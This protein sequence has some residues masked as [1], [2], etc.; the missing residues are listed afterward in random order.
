M[1]Y[2]LLT[3]INWAQR[4]IWLSEF[5]LICNFSLRHSTY[6]YIFQLHVTFALF[7]L[8]RNL[9]PTRTFRFHEILMLANGCIKEK[10]LRT[11]IMRPAIQRILRYSGRIN[12][13]IK[14][15]YVYIFG[16]WIAFYRKKN[17]YMH[18]EAPKSLFVINIS[19]STK[20]N[21]TWGLG[22]KKAQNLAHYLRIDDFKIY[23]KGHLIRI[24]KCSIFHN[25][26]EQV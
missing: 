20:V 9:Q 23:N 8:Q 17:F 18:W 25:I 11:I 21:L 19:S 2:C 24:S 15:Y 26:Q 7:L 6:S 16:G 10:F 14:A 1:Q 22:G 3:S 4:Y 12:I 5:V 13:S